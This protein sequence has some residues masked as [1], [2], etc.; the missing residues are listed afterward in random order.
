MLSVKALRVIGALTGIGRA[1]PCVLARLVAPVPCLRMLQQHSCV[2]GSLQRGY[3]QATAAAPSVS[4]STSSG[5]QPLYPPLDIAKRVVLLTG[6]SAPS[7]AV[8]PL[9]L[10]VYELKRSAEPE[11]L[12]SWS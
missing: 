4:R 1:D 12:W 5:R 9:I 10:L 2:A 8:P 11:T 3:A 7:V 6:V